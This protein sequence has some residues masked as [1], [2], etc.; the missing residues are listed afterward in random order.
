[1]ILL[2]F[3]HPITDAQRTRS[4]LLLTSQQESALNR[5]DLCPSLVRRNHVDVCHR[6]MTNVARVE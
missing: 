4:S 6:I 2:N 3:S 1:M 5:S